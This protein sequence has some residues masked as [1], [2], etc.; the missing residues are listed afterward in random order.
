VN[1]FFFF[2]L[3]NP[4]GRIWPWGFTQPVTE[5]STR[6]R[7]I[8]F[9]GSRARPVRK[10]ATLTPSVIRFSRQCGSLDVSRPYM[11]PRPVT[12]I[13][14]CIRMPPGAHVPQAEDHCSRERVVLRTE[15]RTYV[16]RALVE[17]TRESKQWQ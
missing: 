3:H 4:S 6:S 11:P 1:E 17:Q 8:M 9:L 12:G 2:I 16:L 5:M 15:D 7:Q 10:L 14:I 13:G